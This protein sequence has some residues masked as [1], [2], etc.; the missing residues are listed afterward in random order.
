MTPA[1]FIA[2]LIFGVDTYDPT[3]EF[4]LIE[5]PIHCIGDASWNFSSATVSITT[6]AED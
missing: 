5:C 3:E 4:V 1:Q 2:K 6:Q